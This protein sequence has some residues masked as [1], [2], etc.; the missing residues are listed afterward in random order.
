MSL[1]ATTAEL[2]RITS[3]GKREACLIV[4]FSDGTFAGRHV[5][6]GMGYGGGVVPEDRVRGW[7]L[8]NAQEECD[9]ECKTRGIPS[10][11]VKWES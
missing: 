6:V 9:F 7:L 10:I 2:S 11:P 3:N 5:A 4:D 1:T 8:R